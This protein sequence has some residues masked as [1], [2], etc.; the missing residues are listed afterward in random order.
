[1]TRPGSQKLGEVR[2]W[3]EK[4]TV[5]EQ[6]PAKGPGMVHSSLKSELGIAGGFVLGPMCLKLYFQVV[7]WVE[8][9]HHFRL[10][11]KTLMHPKKCLLCIWGSED[12]GKV[13]G[14]HVC[15]GIPRESNRKLEPEV[16]KNVRPRNLQKCWKSDD[17][18]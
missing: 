10:N 12:Q 8:V 2:G 9:I 18:F 4:G 5:T 15:L 3:R 11:S 16:T 13:S 14:F 1:M 17:I 7:W 6:H